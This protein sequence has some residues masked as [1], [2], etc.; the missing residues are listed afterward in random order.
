MSNWSPPI[1]IS[2][3]RGDIHE[4]MPNQPHI[5]T[6]DSVLGQRWVVS[7]EARSRRLR[8]AEPF[9]I[10][11]S[12]RNTYEIIESRTHQLGLF[13]GI[14]GY[15]RQAGINT[16]GLNPQVEVYEADALI[17]GS[18]LRNVSMN[19]IREEIISQKS[20]LAVDL[21]ELGKTKDM[22]ATAGRDLFKV[23]RSLRGGTGLRD[24]ILRM[25]RD[26]WKSTA[27]SRWL[28]YIYGW[29]P[30]LSGA[31]ETA[32]VLNTDW[33]KSKVYQGKTRPIKLRRDYTKKNRFGTFVQT[34][35]SIGVGYYEY[36]ISDKNLK[37]FSDL[38]FT[39]PLSIAWELTPW[40]FVIDWFVDVG[41]Y[42]NRMDF[43][44]G[45]SNPWGQVSIR[46]RSSVQVEAVL[47]GG[48][49]PALTPAVGTFHCLYSDRMLPTN[50][51]PN[52]YMG[53]KRFTN[54]AVR[55]TS[56]VALLNQQLSQIRKLKF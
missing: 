1:T 56:A 30:T 18:Y 11:D 54:E 3:Q 45:S 28:E 32:S 42:I 6:K 44:L 47:R 19:R 51:I 41:G 35:N 24:F 22:F 33:Q 21:A 17:S 14:D 31:F 8:P 9:R 50:S 34:N 25:Q 5:I 13:V 27:G 52:T 46:K 20:Q 2:T 39:N 15:L 55:L 26:G 40:S 29:A 7:G 12:T 49:E 10:K 37:T 16:V 48:L 36:T 43:S 38:G 4:Y 53:V 23:F